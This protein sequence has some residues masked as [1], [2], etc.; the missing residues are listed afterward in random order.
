MWTVKFSFDC[1]E[2]LFGKLAK[3]FNLE[4]T[5][6]PISSYEQSKQLYLNIVGT[7]KGNTK[8][9][10]QFIKKLKKEKSI[11]K[12]EYN[13]DLLN[14]L[15]IE[16]KKY[17]PFYSPYFIY[18]SP[19]KVDSQGRYHYYLGSWQREELNKLI[20]HVKSNYNFKFKK[21]VQ[22]KL[23][24]ISILGLQPNL[25]EKQSNSYEL[26]TKEGYYEYPKQI[27]LKQ[28]AKLSKISYSTFQQHL[29]YA[30]KKISKFF[31][32]RY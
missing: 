19:V 14:I 13:N 22:E 27:D 30:E 16:D 6:Y 7:I 11:L 9:K 2:I 29:K 28:L 12:L 10:E 20:S 5:G 4:L 1:E 26:A 18:I 32:G 24:N 15:L 21:I 8:D 17:S 25:T 3:R 31:S 23:S